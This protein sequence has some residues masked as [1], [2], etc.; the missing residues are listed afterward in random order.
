[1]HEPEARLP[2]ISVREAAI[3]YGTS[4][5]DIRRRIKRGTLRAESIARPGGT[6]LRV[7]LD[8]PEAAPADTS[9]IEGEVTP[10]PRQDAPGALQAIT[11]AWTDERAERQ[12]LAVENAALRERAGRA[13]TRAD[14]LQAALDRERRPWWRKLL[15]GA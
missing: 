11:D 1:M 4:E 13:E 6:L 12:R 3:R 7:L 15:D 9:H 5:S 14:M 2:G 10:E 8:E